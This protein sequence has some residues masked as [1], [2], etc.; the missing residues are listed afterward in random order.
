FVV[1]AVRD[2]WMVVTSRVSQ[3]LVLSADTV[4]S[5]DGEILGKPQDEEEAARMLRKLAGRD[6]WVYTA[7]TVINQVRQQT[8]DGLDRTRVWS[9]SLSDEQIRDYPR[10]DNASAT[11]DASAVPSSA[12]DAIAKLVRPYCNVI[13]LAVALV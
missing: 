13:G 1:S 4:V 5:I 8:L 6:H 12:G 7:V 9:Q 11:A 2:K 10:R 3:S